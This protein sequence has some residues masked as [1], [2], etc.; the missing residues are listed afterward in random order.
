M[1]D[2]FS[3][4]VWKA[5]PSNRDYAVSSLGRV[6]SAAL[7]GSI[8]VMSISDNGKGYKL[9]SVNRPKR[10][11]HYVHRLVA[12]AFVPN[13][14]GKGEVNHIDG[15]KSNNRAS[16]LEWT[17]LQENRDHSKRVG[18]TLKGEELASSKL[19]EDAVRE[20]RRIIAQDPMTN[21]TELGKRY[22]VNCTAIIKVVKRQ[23]W[24]HVQD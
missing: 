14:D 22:G 18:L 11:N 6:C 19:T 15:N 3:K 4:E 24:K 17:T 10:K 16:N 12:E 13:P 2:D 5:L 8:R 1:K 21:K 9:I 23:R 7:G 20:I